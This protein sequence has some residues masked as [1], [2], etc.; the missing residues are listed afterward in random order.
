METHD[1][2]MFAGINASLYTQLGGIEP[3][4]PGYGTVD[5]RPAGPA[6][7]SSTSAASIDTPKGTVATSWTRTG[8]QLALDV[9]VPVGT[10]ATV[11]VPQ[12]G[13]GTPRSPPRTAPACCMATAP[14][15]VTR[16]APG[17]GASS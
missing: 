3:T 1:H 13:G 2:A 4:G 8:G 14:G 17:T 12:S 11:V 5:H 7:A 10:T 9:T 16:S 15:P 6:G